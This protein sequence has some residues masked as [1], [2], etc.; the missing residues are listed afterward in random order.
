MRLRLASG[1][2][3]VR[4]G[5]ALGIVLVR[6]GLG[7]RVRDRHITTPVTTHIRRNPVY[8]NTK[9]TKEMSTKR[10]AVCLILAAFHHS[11]A[12]EVISLDSTMSRGILKNI[13]HK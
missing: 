11:S 2:V 3:L 9:L 12:G 13:Q 7:L 1:I 6:L 4:L 10:P 8:T 5:L